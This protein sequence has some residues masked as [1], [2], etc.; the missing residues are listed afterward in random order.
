MTTIFAFADRGGRVEIDQGISGGA[1][2]D[3]I[4]LGAGSRRRRRRRPALG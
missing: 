1:G 4:L 2:E 3:F